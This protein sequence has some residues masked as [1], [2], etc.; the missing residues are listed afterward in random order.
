MMTQKLKVGGFSISGSSLQDV[1]SPL[2]HYGLDQGQPSAEL[3]LESGLE[4]V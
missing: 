1:S 3:L 2:L 4:G